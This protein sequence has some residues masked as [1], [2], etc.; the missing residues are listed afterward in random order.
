MR[1]IIQAVI[2]AVA[3]TIGAFYG[4]HAERQHFANDF[5]AWSAMVL[6]DG[7]VKPAVLEPGGGILCEARHPVHGWQ[8][9]G[10]PG[11]GR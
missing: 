3:I 9:F 1:I 6:P 8:K 2:V 11:L 4:K 10:L 7:E 5:C